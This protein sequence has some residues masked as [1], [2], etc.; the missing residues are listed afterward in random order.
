MS[1]ININD[2]FQSLPV[3]IQKEVRDYIEFLVFKYANQK[4]KKS[5]IKSSFTFKWEGAIKKSKLSS[6]E[7]QHLSNEWRNS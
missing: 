6:V 7:L 4:T 2:Q 3:N 5:K 1:T